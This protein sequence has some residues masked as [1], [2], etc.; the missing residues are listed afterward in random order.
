MLKS[1]LRGWI[2]RS[3]VERGL[4]KS[5][6]TWLIIGAFSLL[7][8]FYRASGKK[9]ERVALSERIRPGDE[10]VLRYPGKPDRKT[11]KE[12][13]QVQKRRTAEQVARDAAVAALQRR[14]QRSGRAGKRAAKE[15]AR[16]IG[17]AGSE[18]R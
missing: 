12:V 14:A 4:K 17:N 8:R 9:S 15:L 7:K 6:P 16:F 5:S 18:R 2:G 1:L 3:V 13:T 11:R 10:L